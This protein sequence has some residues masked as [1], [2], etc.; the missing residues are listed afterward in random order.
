VDDSFSYGSPSRRR[1]LDRRAFVHALA[2]AGSVL[3][4]FGLWQLY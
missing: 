2:A 3:A 1:G 4:L